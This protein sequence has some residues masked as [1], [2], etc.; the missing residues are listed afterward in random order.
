MREASIFCDESGGENGHSKYYLIT[1]VFHDQDD[2]I[3]EKMS[4]YERALNAKGLS[5]VP[6]HASPCMNGHDDYRNMGIE[7]RKKM[8]MHFFIFQRN[9]PYRYKTFA[10]RRK[11]VGDTAKLVARFKRDLVVFLADN[12][13]YFQSFDHVK[14]YYDGG[15]DTVSK[16]LRAA[17]DYVLSKNAVM[18]RSADPRDYCF[19]QV[20][21]FICTL[22]LTAIKFDHHEL[23]A[24]DEKFFGLSEAAFKKL[25]LRHVRKKQL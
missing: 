11:V 15:Q 6:F 5:N 23:T 1:L 25:Y 19:S 3:D 12:L 17:I 21:D 18:Y 10:Y 13:E 16:A 2:P 4:D 24:T 14:I 22:E 20:A 7:T 8:L 9:L